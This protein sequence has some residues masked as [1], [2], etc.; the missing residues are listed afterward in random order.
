MGIKPMIWY[1]LRHAEKEQGDFHNPQL[2]H[3]DQ[4]LSARGQQAALK[5]VANFADKPITAIYV[6]AYQ[7]TWQTIAAVAEHLQ[8]TPVVDGRLNEI[9]N[10]DVDGMTERDFQQV[11][12]DVW[13]A[14]IARRA[15][16]RFPGGETG[17]EVQERIKDFFD[18]KRGQHTGADI[19][20]VSHDGLIRQM[21][22]YVM[23]LPVYRRG[24]FRVDL[25]GLMELSYQD[26][27]DRWQLLRFNQ[28]CG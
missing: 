10:G 17:A 14:Y 15:D 11:Y 22:C 26:D 16:F 23:G 6:S 3:Q 1:I 20:L 8:I 9:D 24:D 21:M 25:C 19:L 27:C 5:L 18:E 4:P 12:P 28:A 2:R 7:R 13:R